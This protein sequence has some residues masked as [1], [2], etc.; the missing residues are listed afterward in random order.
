MKK[1]IPALLFVCFVATFSFALPAKV[2]AKP[3][4]QSNSIMISQASFKNGRVVQKFDFSLG[5]SY[6]QNL[7]LNAEQIEK[8]KE[9][10]ISNVTNFRN[11]IAINLTLIYAS[12][13]LQN[14]QFALGND[15]KISQTEYVSDNVTFSVIYENN[16]CWKF[17]NSKPSSDESPDEN[18]NEIS[19]IQSSVS[20]GLFPF[21]QKVTVGEEKIL[22]G[23]RYKNAYLKAFEGSDFYGSI[24]TTY[25]P[26]FMYNYATHYNKIKSD[27]CMKFYGEDGLYHHV[28]Q[29]S[30]EQLEN[31]KITISVTQAIKGWWYLTILVSTLGGLGIAILIAFIIKKKKIYKNKES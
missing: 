1:F 20:T 24:L 31:A 8:G 26:V 30:E 16:E 14:P 15:L 13:S 11:D 23:T 6:L 25:N 12:S 28:W 3:T 9:N 10:L 2:E 19:F 22:L 27:A 4:S 17:Y 18:K 5:K 29:N 7:G 21:S